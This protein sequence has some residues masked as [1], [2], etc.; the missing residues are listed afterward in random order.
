ME[1][2]LTAQQTL[3]WQRLM[4]FKRE[5]LMS[6]TTELETTK[7]F[8]PDM[9]AAIESQLPPFGMTPPVDRFSQQVLTV[10]ALAQSSASLAMIIASWWQVQDAVLAFGTPKQQQRYLDQPELLGLPSLA[11]PVADS[12]MLQAS[13]VADGWQLSGTVSKVLNGGQAASYLVMAQTTPETTGI[14]LVAAEQNGIT[15]NPA[16][17]TLGLNGLPLADLQLTDV[18][19]TAADQLGQWGQGAEIMQRAQALGRLFAGAVT[20]GVWHHATEKARQLALTEQPPLAQLAPVIAMTS[21]LEASVFNVA[22]LADEQQVFVPAANSVMLFAS[23]MATQPLA[24]LTPLIGELAYTQHSPLMALQHDLDTLPLLVGTSAVIAD[25]F[26]MVTLNSQQNLS[27]VAMPTVALEKLAI[28]DL[29]RVVKHLN[30]TKDVPVNVGSIATAKRIVAL[31]RGATDPAVLLQAQQ[32]AKWIGAAFAVTQPLTMM[33]QFSI[34][35][36]IGAEAVMVAPEVLINIGV[37]GDE[38]YLAGMAGAQHILSVN[39]DEQAPI[40]DHSQQVFVGTATEFLDG[41]VAALN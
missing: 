38:D 41:M 4:T 1:L 16:V 40:F 15:M 27:P 34:E 33:E 31:G 11:M 13:P 23:Q 35:Q 10:M 20:A 12:D 2:Q 25:E 3:L 36:R 37:S 18:K 26:A 22:Q 17:V 24:T 21:A 28:S 32:L 30:L 5:Q 19:V 29:H 9:L 8:N 14:F 6:M 39:T 7:T